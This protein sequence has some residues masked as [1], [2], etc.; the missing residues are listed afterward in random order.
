MA[1]HTQVPSLPGLVATGASATGGALAGVTHQLTRLRRAQKPLHP[2]GSVVTARLTRTGGSDSG[3]GWLDDPGEDEVLVRI[4]RA[5]GLPAVVPDIYGL[6]L[7]IPTAEGPAD[8]LLAT[9]GLGRLTRFVLTAGREV[10]AR[11][12]TTLL[13]YRSPRGPLLLAA[14]PVEAASDGSAARFDLRWSVGLG[15]W[16]T[17]AVLDVPRTAGPDPAISFD[18]V[19]NPPPGLEQYPWVRRLR[20]PAYA[21]ARRTAAG[22][23]SCPAALRPRSDRA[24]DVAVL[25]PVAEEQA[26]RDHPEPEDQVQ[27]VVGGIERDEVGVVVTVDHEPVHGQHQVDGAAAEEERA[28]AA[29]TAGQHEPDDPES[30]VHEV[31]EHR[32]R[33]DAEQLGTGVVPDELHLVVVGRD[34]R[35]ESQD[36]D[37]R[38]RGRHHERGLLEEGR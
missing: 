4:S 13:P 23:D 14:V 16:T 7:R 30:Q 38:E 8:V 15:P 35:N 31:V 9:T 6:A 24:T 17:F 21:A 25:R 29:P 5:I 2:A 22:P 28:G 12:L 26:E 32:H 1:A 18:A 37:E 20:E 19:E 33:E 36:A 27:P 34:P 11:P 10:T 3:V